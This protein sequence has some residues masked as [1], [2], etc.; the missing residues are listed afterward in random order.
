MKDAAKTMSGRPAS[1]CGSNALVL[2]R[3]SEDLAW[4]T[5]RRNGRAHGHLNLEKA[6]HIRDFFRN[7]WIPEHNKPSAN[8]DLQRAVIE[9]VEVA[10]QRETQLDE[11]IQARLEA[12]CDELKN[13]MLEA[14]GD[15]TLLGFYSRDPALIDAA[16]DITTRSSNIV[17]LKK[18]QSFTV[19]D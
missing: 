11:W 16:T 15:P 3:H 5:L 19:R 7:C 2:F 17:V 8:Q 18:G 1:A 10:R 14:L 6:Q 12:E 4:L 9:L 13:I